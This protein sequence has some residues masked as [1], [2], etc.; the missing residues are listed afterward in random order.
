MNDFDLRVRLLRSRLDMSGAMLAANAAVLRLL[1]GQARDSVGQKHGSPIE[2]KR[3]PQANKINGYASTFFTVDAAKEAVMPGAFSESLAKHRAAGTAPLMLWQHN[4]EEVIGVW[5]ALS[6]DARG[7]VATGRLLPSV[8]RGAEAADLIDA[9]ALNGLSIGYKVLRDEM[10][11]VTGVRKLLKLFLL[12]ISIV[13]FPANSQ[14]RLSGKEY[15][16][17]DWRQAIERL[18]EAAKTLTQW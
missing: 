9:G 18:G 14:A 12:E 5:E 7:L 15:G 10:D 11:P 3:A 16:D 17:D 2:F 1:A 6:E 4:R 13:S 8:R